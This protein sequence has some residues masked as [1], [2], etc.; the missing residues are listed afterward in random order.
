MFERETVLEAILTRISTRSFTGEVISDEIVDTILRA[1]FAAPTANN[2]RPWEFI[3][4]KNQETIDQM[5][6]NMPNAKA[7]QG[8]GCIIVVLGD[9]QKQALE[10]YVIQDCSAAIENMLLIAHE[11]QLGGLWCGVYPRESR[12]LGIKDIL[13]LPEH[14]LPVGVVAI[15]YPSEEAKRPPYD[16]YD[17]EKVHFEKY[18]KK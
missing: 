15:G 4:I 17:P 6:D 13:G 9:L 5:V 2:L 12:I 7:A 11:M 8:A 14:I 18:N 10:G 16:K 1:G 3:V